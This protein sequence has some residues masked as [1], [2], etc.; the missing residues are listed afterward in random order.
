MCVCVRVQKLVTLGEETINTPVYTQL[1]NHQCHLVIDQLG[2]YALVGES[3][4]N[5][6]TQLANGA[7]A[8]KNMRLAVFA[9]PIQQSLEYSLK[10]YVVEDTIAAIDV[11]FINFSLKYENIY[12]YQLQSINW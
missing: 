12:I 11:S 7:G 1:D 4:A 6:K 5:T 8:S 2:H 10:C 3:K 9:S